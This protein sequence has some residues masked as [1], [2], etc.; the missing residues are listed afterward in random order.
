[1]IDDPDRPNRFFQPP[2]DDPAAGAS[3]RP[4]VLVG[5]V[6]WA[7]LLLF[8][9]PA[10]AEINCSKEVLCIETRPIDTGVQFYALN[11]KQHKTSVH[12]DVKMR[13]MVS[14]TGLPTVFV[15]EGDSRKRLFTL[16]R[17]AGAWDYT[18]HYDWMP[19]DVHAQHDDNYR[20][21]LPFPVRQRFRVAQSCNGSFTH[22]EKSQNA[23]DFDMPVGTPVH[24]AR[25]GLV[26]DLKDDADRGGNTKIYEDDANYVLIEHADGT[27]GEYYHL[28][29]NGA[30]VSIGQFVRK[31]TLIGYSGNTGYSAG[32]HLHFA[33][34]T[35]TDG[36]TSIS[37]PVTFITGEG[38]ATCPSVNTFLT[39]E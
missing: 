14:D 22:T 36:I 9:P 20:Y 12:M 25:E 17:D 19:G 23:I 7:L 3:A 30:A 26:V 16:T 37:V 34:G 6:C 4:R 28:R 2:A 38:P 10:T 8:S 15:V 32:P 21:R 1:M 33:V 11:K 35:T 18:Y 5:V 24:A 13:N 27:L 29:K 39:A 31:G